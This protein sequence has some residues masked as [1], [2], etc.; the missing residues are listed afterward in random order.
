MKQGFGMLK[1]QPAGLSTLF[2]GYM[3]LTTLLLVVPLVGQ[4]AH[5]VLM[6]V[7]AIGFMAATGHPSTARPSSRAATARSP[8]TWRTTWR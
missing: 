8:A 2:F 5:S 4:I 6:P 7:F 3:L 1:K